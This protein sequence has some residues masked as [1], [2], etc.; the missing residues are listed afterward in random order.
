MKL[1]AIFYLWLRFT[2]INLFVNVNVSGML[3][4]ENL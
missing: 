2:N 1:Q 3:Q 4:E